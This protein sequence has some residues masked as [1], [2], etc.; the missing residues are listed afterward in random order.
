LG[1]ATQHIEVRFTD[2]GPGID[3]AVQKNLFI[4]FFTTKEKGTGLGLAISQRI[5]ENH[6]GFIEVRTRQSS[7]SA[8]PGMGLASSP[9]ASS[10]GSTN[11]PGTTF[12]VVLPVTD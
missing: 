6:D 12:L 3:P 4:P 8:S 5:V 9:T 10:S 11:T 7:P 1:G 2:T